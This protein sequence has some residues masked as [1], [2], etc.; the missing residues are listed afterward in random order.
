MSAYDVCDVVMLVS[1][2]VVARCEDA[3][4]D[5]SGFFL[6]DLEDAERIARMLAEEFARI[7]DGEWCGVW[8][9]DV[10]EPLGAYWCA[11]RNA[12]DDAIRA[13]VRE[14][15][16]EVMNENDESEGV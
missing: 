10:A 7:P 14:L 6:P 8:G 15:V 11:N 5:G 16:A 4:R 3:N 1:G 9:Y 13:K 2:F 12:S